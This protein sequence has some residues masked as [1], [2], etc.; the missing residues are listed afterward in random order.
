MIFVLVTCTK[1]YE[2]EEYPTLILYIILLA[3]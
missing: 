1:I 3:A 2:S